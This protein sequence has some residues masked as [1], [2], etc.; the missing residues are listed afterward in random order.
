MKSQMAVGVSSQP[1]LSGMTEPATGAEGSAQAPKAEAAIN[2][3]RKIFSLKDESAQRI[4]FLEVTYLVGL[5]N[6][7]KLTL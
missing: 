5:S 4:Q 6:L 7:V 1:Q 3:V 2:Y